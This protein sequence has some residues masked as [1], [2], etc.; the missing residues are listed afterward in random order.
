MSVHL[1]LDQTCEVGHCLRPARRAAEDLACGLPEGCCPD[2]L[3]D[4]VAA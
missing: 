3:P 2:T 4:W 1:R